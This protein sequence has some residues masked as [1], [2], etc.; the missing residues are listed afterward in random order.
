MNPLR[1]LATA[2]PML[3]PLAIGPTAARAGESLAPAGDDAQLMVAGLLVTLIAAGAAIALWRQNR[4]LTLAVAARDDALSR[5]EHLAHRDPLTGLPNRGLIADRL[6]QAI[7]RAERQGRKVAVC[8]AGLDGFQRI[9]DDLGRD[10]GD[11]L[12]AALGQRLS[13]RLRATDTVGRL[14]DDEFVLVLEEI[15]D[16]DAALCLARDIQ[17]VIGEALEVNGRACTVAASIG[18]AFYPDHG[19][20][21]PTLLRKADMALAAARHQGSSRIATHSED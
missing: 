12:L 15:D 13:I 21:T 14:G 8:C 1:H 11:A 2:W 18:I 20:D 6:S 16:A 5:L 10:A 17:Q 3:L 19:Q 4:R 9:N 7:Y